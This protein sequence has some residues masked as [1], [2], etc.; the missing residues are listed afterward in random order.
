MLI[1]A[2]GDAGPLPWSWAALAAL[3]VWRWVERPSPQ[4]VSIVPAVHERAPGE[5]CFGELERG[6][7]ALQLARERLG[8]WQSAAAALA[9]LA[10]V[11]ALL[12]L[13]LARRAASP[14]SAPAPAR[15]RVPF[16][17]LVRESSEEDS[18]N[19]LA[20]EPAPRPTSFRKSSFVRGHAVNVGGRR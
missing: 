12:T 1:P 13:Y 7:E 20:W 17:P 3:L 18:D 2:A 19:T 10:F 15:S 6:E 14:A 9:A 8:W 16:L 4:V 5:E 11:L